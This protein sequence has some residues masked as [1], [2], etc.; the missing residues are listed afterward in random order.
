[1]DCCPGLHVGFGNSKTV[2][3][4]DFLRIRGVVDVTPW[5]HFV[6]GF[7]IARCRPVQP[8]P[9]FNPPPPRQTPGLMVF[10]S[11]FHVLSNLSAQETMNMP[12]EL[13][14]LY[15]ST[16]EVAANYTLRAVVTGRLIVQLLSGAGGLKPPVRLS[17]IA[18]TAHIAALFLKPDY[19]ATWIV[20]DT[21]AGDTE[22]WV[23]VW[24]F[25]LDKLARAGR[26]SVALPCLEH[27]GFLVVQF[28]SWQ[29]GRRTTVRSP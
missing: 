26:A 13:R 4:N 17:T 2:C 8:L 5:Y 21:H 25:L 19:A 10:T 20:L 18:D 28:V 24:T 7:R 22:E 14:G 23:R 6:A 29:R 15:S 11:A 27:L 12:E 1:M 16:D 3:G 9:P